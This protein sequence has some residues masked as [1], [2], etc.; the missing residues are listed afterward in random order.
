MKDTEIGMKKES[1]LLGIVAY[2]K[3]EAPKHSANDTNG[4]ISSTS[5]PA[6][7]ARAKAMPCSFCS[8]VLRVSRTFKSWTLVKYANQVQ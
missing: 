3:R 7:A 1:A 8:T 2:I 4:A 5:K 6:A